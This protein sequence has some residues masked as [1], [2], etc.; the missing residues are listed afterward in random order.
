MLAVK[1]EDME[2]T[3]KR[4][5]WLSGL[6]SGTPLRVPALTRMEICGHQVL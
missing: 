6:T 4:P 1:F 2:E 5:G 3:V